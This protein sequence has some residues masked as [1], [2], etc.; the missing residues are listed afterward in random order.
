MAQAMLRTSVPVYHER[1]SLKLSHFR[2]IR[3]SL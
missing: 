2:K 3:V 1:T